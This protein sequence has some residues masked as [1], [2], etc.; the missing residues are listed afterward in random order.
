MSDE[1]RLEEN[2]LSE[3]AET[4]LSTQLDKVEKIDVDVHTDLLK[5]IQGQADSV[6]LAGE[7]I[8]IKDIRI[9]EIQLKTD[10]I[11]VNPFSAIF[12]Q[13]EFNQPVNTFARLVVTQADLNHALESNYIRSK[14]KK[15]DLNVDGKIVSLHPQQMQIILPGEGKMKFNGKVLLKE[16]N[17][18]R[19]VGFTAMVRP[20]TSSNPILMEN[21]NCTEGD[22]ISLNIMVSLMNKVKELVNL[23]YF[24]IDDTKFRILNMDTQ[25][26]SLILLVEARVQQIPQP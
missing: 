7:G 18:T 2:L 17:N 12:G 15:F 14:I 19:Q 4:T 25:E 11:A 21:F 3:I 20:R 23:P 24:Q 10:N 5:I 9:Q 6:S 22:G 16:K 1:R 13:I 26:G 8:E